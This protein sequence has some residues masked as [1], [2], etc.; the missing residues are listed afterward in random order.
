MNKDKVLKNINREFNDNY[1]SL[2]DIDDVDIWM[3][4][5]EY[6]NLSEDF[7][8]K[9]QHKVNWYY[10]SKRQKLSET[11]IRKFK[12]KVDWLNILLYQKLSEEF[13]GEIDDNLTLNIW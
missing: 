4:V 2:G 5:S 1:E 3:W 7:I 10:I 11:F 13:K 12:N 6:Q 8:E 9:F